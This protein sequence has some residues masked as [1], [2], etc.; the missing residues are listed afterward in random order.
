MNILGFCLLPCK[1]QWLIDMNSME[2]PR[3]SGIWPEQCKSHSFTWNEAKERDWGLTMLPYFV[4]I[5]FV[6]VGF[7]FAFYS[8][9]MITWTYSFS[10]PEQA[11][12][13]THGNRWLCVPCR[14]ESELGGVLSC[15]W[16]SSPCHFMLSTW[17]EWLSPLSGAG[18]HRTGLFNLKSAGFQALCWQ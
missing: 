1:W 2:Q 3:P 13:R 6:V 15:G 16:C 7:W 17:W 4:L 18:H 12:T 8:K 9:V 14:G 10:P 5:G 11:G